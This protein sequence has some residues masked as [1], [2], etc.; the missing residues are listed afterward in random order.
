MKTSDDDVKKPLYCDDHT[1]RHDEEFAP[2]VE[3]EA[4]TGE[5]LWLKSK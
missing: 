4:E 3:E 2:R 1:Q 5:P